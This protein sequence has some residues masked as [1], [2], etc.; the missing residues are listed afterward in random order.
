MV[1]VDSNSYLLVTAMVIVDNNV[2][3]PVMGMEMKMAI[4]TIAEQ[5]RN[6]NKQQTVSLMMATPTDSPNTILV[7]H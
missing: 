3:T 4:T 5:D 1:M 7:A 6:S 2:S